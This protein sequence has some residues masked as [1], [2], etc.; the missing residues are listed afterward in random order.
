MLGFFDYTVWLTYLSLL[1]ASLG[2]MVT[3]NGGGHPYMGVIFLL[4]CGLCDAFDGRVARTKADRTDVQKKFGIQIDSLSD[5]AAF[6]ILPACIGNAMIRV[7]PTIYEIP[8]VKGGRKLDIYTSIL[9]Y[10]IILVYILAAMVRL[11]YFN[12]LE[13]ERQKNET[14]SRKFYLG[15]PVTSA[16]LVFPTVMLCQF[17][18][19]ADITPLYFVFLLVMA[20]AFVTSIKIPKPGLRGILIMCGIGLV[21][22]LILILCFFKIL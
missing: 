19:T 22:L 16:A 13:E 18:T 4:I 10:T 3:L 15:V 21:E 9:F 17:L 6:G 5:L 1:S 8:P 11:A 20:I 2:I 7:C 12:V 14:G